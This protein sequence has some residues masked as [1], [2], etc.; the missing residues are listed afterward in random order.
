MSTINIG[1]GSSKFY[2][3]LI[4]AYLKQNKEVKVISGGIRMNLGVW[5]YYFAS[6][7][8]KVSKPR[9]SYTEDDR[10]HTV[11][12]F[13]VYDEPPE[14]PELNDY[15]CL[16]VKISKHSKI[17]SLRTVLYNAN[18]VQIIAAGALCHKALFLTT[19]AFKYGYQLQDIEVIWTGDRVGI[20][21]KVYKSS[22]DE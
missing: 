17:R 9:V 2:G 18:D 12:E 7:E 3:N 13:T 14:Q 11:F 1:R 5:V 10:I 16:Q 19:F 8:H 21:I 4:K 15:N 22:V 20:R 6:K